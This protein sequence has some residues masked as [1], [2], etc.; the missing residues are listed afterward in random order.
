MVK[1]F[2]LT[3][4]SNRSP[5][6]RELSPLPQSGKL[7]KLFCSNGCFTS[8]HQTFAVYSRSDMSWVHN[9]DKV[10]R[11]PLLRTAYMV[12]LLHPSMILV[13]Y[14]ITRGNRTSVVQIVSCLLYPYTRGLC[15]KT[16]YCRNERSYDGEISYH[17]I[18]ETGS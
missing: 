18:K 5:S 15:Y 2:G 3:R 8:D 12:I 6:E 16:D 7:L 1:R 17:V 13:K 9:H 10:C 4:G 11:R 14:F